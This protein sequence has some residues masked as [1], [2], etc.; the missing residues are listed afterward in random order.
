MHGTKHAMETVNGLTLVVGRRRLVDWVA[1]TAGVAPGSTVVDVGCGPGSAARAAANRGAH[2]IGVDPSPAMLRLAERFTPRRLASTIEYERGT[3]EHLPVPDAMA[4]IV[5]AIASAHHFADIA[6]ALREC[7]RICTESGTVLVVERHVR[8][9]ARGHAAHGLTDEGAEET[10]GAAFDAGF[11][12]VRTETVA[13]GRKRFV[14]V[15]A[16]CE[17]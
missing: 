11:A 8:P 6:T 7:R 10:A 4:D 12:N 5:W 1:E 16:E 14:L 9:G 15:R 13:L 2:V 17:G 3:A